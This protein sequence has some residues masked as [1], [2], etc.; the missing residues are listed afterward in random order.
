MDRRRY[1]ASGRDRRP[2]DITVLGTAKNSYQGQEGALKPMHRCLF[3]KAG[4]FAMISIAALGWTGVAAQN[5]PSTQNAPDAAAAQAT[6][7]A[8]APAPAAQTVPEDR[9]KVDFSKSR[10][11]FPNLLAPYEGRTLSSPRLDNS[12]R[13]NQLIHEGKLPL[14]LNDAIALALEN[15]LDLAIARYNLDIADTDILRTKAGSSARGVNTG[16]VSGTPGGGVGGFG[17][18]ASGAGAGGTSTGAGGAG[19]G[20]GGLVTSTSGVGPSV[21]NFD[22]FLTTGL[23]IEHSTFPLSNTVTAG[24]PSLQQNTGTANFGY[25]QGFATGTT[26]QVTYNNNRQTSNSIRTSLVPVINSSMRFSI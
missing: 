1:S 10:K 8:E 5:A 15:N 4:F 7:P 11:S 21:P 20:A 24:V 19:S 26:F 2:G 16:V 25:T 13:I 12:P 17:S 23:S 6:A 22:P 14:S 3:S 9:H 18:G